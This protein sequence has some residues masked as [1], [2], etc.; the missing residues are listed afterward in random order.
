MRLINADELKQ[1]FEPR[2]AYFTEGIFRKID[3][4]PSAVHN[5]TMEEV[6]AYI[7]NMPEDVWQEFIGCLEIRG[8]ELRNTR[9]Q[10]C[11]SDF[12]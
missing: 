5:I 6:L 4:V 9:S 12:A 7:D 10:F 2:Q 3:E 8:L 1:K 11:G